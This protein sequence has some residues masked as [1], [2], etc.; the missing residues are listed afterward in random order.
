LNKKRSSLTSAIQAGTLEA[1]Q[2]E[3][4]SYTVNKSIADNTKDTV[5]R[6]D[7]LI[8]QNKSK[9]TEESVNVFA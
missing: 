6:L 8:S 2:L 7:T 1:R 3:T 5:D 4:T 9:S